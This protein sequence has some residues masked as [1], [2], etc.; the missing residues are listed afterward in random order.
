M[1]TK[2][3]IYVVEDN[4]GDILLVRQALKAYA[5]EADLFVAEN[6][7]EVASLLDCAGRDL[8]RPTLL[9]LDLNL[10]RIE[11]PELLRKVREHP[12]CGSAPI[13]VMSSSDTPKDHQWTGQY[14]VSHYFH[15]PSDYDEFLKL[16]DLI[17]NLV[18]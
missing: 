12:V 13:I 10:P 7:D 1:S 8:P 16:G 4:R 6:G 5:I 11:G 3:V 17:R 2:P 18:S 9:L 15:K 14:D